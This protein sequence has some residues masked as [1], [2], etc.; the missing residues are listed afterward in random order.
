MTRGEWGPIP[1]SHFDP[2]P[3]I[4]GTW[5]WY[6]WIPTSILHNTWKKWRGLRPATGATPCQDII[7][8]MALGGTMSTTGPEM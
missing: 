4:T 8:W 1:N 5:E 7:P 2:L 6:H 3:G